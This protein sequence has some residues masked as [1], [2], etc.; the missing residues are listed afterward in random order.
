MPDEHNVFDLG[1]IIKRKYDEINQ[2]V[3]LSGRPAPKNVR[4]Q[5]D[6]GVVVKCDVRYG[7]VNP[8]DGD[9][10]FVVIAEIDWENY[11]PKLLIVEEAPDDVE[12]RFRVPGMTDADS[13]KVL[14]T[15]QFVPERI[16]GVK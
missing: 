10:I 5:L 1:E 12:Y 14:A 4:V 16:I 6:S 11:H 8:A 3:D 9:R 2:Q 13:D 15:L 7:G